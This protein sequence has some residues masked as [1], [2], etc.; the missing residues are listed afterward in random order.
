MSPVQA[1]VHVDTLTFGDIPKLNGLKFL[2]NPVTYFA[3]LNM[4]ELDTDL[5]AISL[6]IGLNKFTEYPLLF[7]LDNRASERHLD[8]EFSVHV[9]FSETIVC[10]VEQGKELSVREAEL[11]CQTW[12]LFIYISQFERINVRDQVTVSHIG[13]K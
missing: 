6:L 10:W 2:S 3:I 4:H 9:S 1:F 8:V 5:T 12:A 13:A 11:L 7:P